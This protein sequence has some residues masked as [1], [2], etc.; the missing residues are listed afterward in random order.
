MVKDYIAFPLLSGIS[1]PT[2]LTA[3]F[4]ANI[5]RNVWT[6]TIIFCGHFPDNVEYFTEEEIEGESQGEW[7]LRQLMGSANIEGSELFHIM[8]GNLSHQIEHHLFPDLPSNRYAEIAP[9]VRAICEEY[10]LPYTS[11]RLSKQ[12]YEVWRSL[13]MLSLP[14]EIRAK[15]SMSA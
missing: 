9:Q 8:S 2:T 13:A 3:N 11:G 14:D 12:S 6:H 7:Y 5:L 10:G 4:T 1:A 15:L